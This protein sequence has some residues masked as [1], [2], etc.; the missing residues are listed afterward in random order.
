MGG[1]TPTTIKTK[2][3]DDLV[4]EEGLERVDFIKMDIEGS[5]LAALKGAKNTIQKYKP[6]LAICIYHKIEDFY[7]IPKYIKEIAP[8]Y[9]LYV[10]HHT[11]MEWET[12][13]YASVR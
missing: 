6:N 9:K 4:K 8:E 12:V 5:E 7:T 1:G 13:L 2:A 10:K 11:D 3:I